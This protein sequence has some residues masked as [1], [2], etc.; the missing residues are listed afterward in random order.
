MLG[1]IGCYSLSDQIIYLIDRDDSIESLF[2]VN[3]EEGLRFIEKLHDRS[4]EKNIL[5]IDENGPLPKGNTGLSVLL[6]LNPGDLHNE[7]ASIRQRQAEILERISGFVDSVLFCYGLC[8]SPEERIA[9]LMREA[10]VPVTFLTDDSG[11]I[12]DDCFAAIIGGKQ[13]YLDHIKEHKGTIFAS[14]GYVE[15]WGRKYRGMDIESI[16]EHVEGMTCMFE[17]M[18]YHQVMVLD[19]GLGDRD[20]F[21]KDVNTFARIF[22]LRLVIKECQLRVFE[23][24]YDHAKEMIDHGEVSE[25]EEMPRMGAR[26]SQPQSKAHVYCFDED[27][28]DPEWP[29][30]EPSTVFSVGRLRRRVTFK[31]GLS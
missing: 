27:K 23:R 17:A 10:R 20:L 6:W 30:P 29:D 25:V 8:R 16:V 3:N 22:D 13:A 15:T 2:I 18:G 24:S 19:D 14:T 5:L 26:P 28:S 4:V 31:D 7:S 9:R 1:I 21:D 12:V 11:E